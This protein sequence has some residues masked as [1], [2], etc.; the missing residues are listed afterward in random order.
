MRAFFCALK[1]EAQAENDTILNFIYF[2]DLK[3]FRRVGIVICSE[4]GTPEGHI[5]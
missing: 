4:T 3:A 1:S 2:S 5:Y